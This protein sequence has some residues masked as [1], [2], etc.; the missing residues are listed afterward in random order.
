MAS[1]LVDLLDVLLL[2]RADGL[3]AAGQ[4]SLQLLLVAQRFPGLPG[5]VFDAQGPQEEAELVRGTV[6]DQQLDVLRHQL[7]GAL[8]LFGEL[9]EQFELL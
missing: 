7:D 1:Q 3:K 2:D 5:L 4:S 9:G 6:G 8:P